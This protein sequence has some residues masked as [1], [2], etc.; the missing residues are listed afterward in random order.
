MH[1]TTLRTEPGQEPV[2]SIFKKCLTAPLHFAPASDGKFVLTKAGTAAL[3]ELVRRYCSA[4]SK[5]EDIGVVIDVFLKTES[6]SEHN[7]TDSR[8]FLALK[9]ERSSYI[10]TSNYLAA[11]SHSTCVQLQNN[12][13]GRDLRLARAS[14]HILLRYYEATDV[15]GPFALRQFLRAGL[16]ADSATNADRSIVERVITCH[17]R[18]MIQFPA[19]RTAASEVHSNLRQAAAGLT[20]LNATAKDDACL[21][22][23]I[24]ALAAILDR[25]VRTQSDRIAMLHAGS[26][27]ALLSSANSTPKPARAPAAIAPTAAPSDAELLPSVRLPS[28]AAEPKALTPLDYREQPNLLETTKLED[29]AT[30]AIFLAQSLGGLRLPPEEQASFLPLIDIVSSWTVSAYGLT[31]ITLAERLFSRNLDGPT[32]LG[33]YYL[34]TL[35]TET[36]TRELVPQLSKQYHKHDLTRLLTPQR[37]SR[38]VQLIHK[39][40]AGA[41]PL[42]KNNLEPLLDGLK[43]G[44]DSDD[45]FYPRLPDAPRCQTGGSVA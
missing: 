21:N 18:S 27:P 19:L 31:P 36:L 37:V 7:F 39:H 11:L 17:L 24:L 38:A 12:L 2:V 33:I 14:A 45:I 30:A 44:F 34:L 23:S 32:V 25:C 20:G 3:H 6:L 22:A 15:K 8:L 28:R 43:L 16:V 4:K 5:R 1:Q 42:A 29:R 41:K 35:P 26:H 9:N 10:G 13:S 40:R